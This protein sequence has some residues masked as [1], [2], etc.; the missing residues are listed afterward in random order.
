MANDIMIPKRR[1]RPPKGLKAA[2]AAAPVLSDAETLAL[3]KSR[4]A[5]LARTTV[6]TADASVRGLIVS[7][8]AG[9]GKSYTVTQV[10]DGL[11]LQGKVKRI[12]AVSG[13]MT[14]VHL[15]MLLWR[16]REKGNVVVIDDADSIY[17]DDSALNVLKAALDTKAKREI[18]WY[19]D[20]AVLK[21]ENVDAQFVFEGSVVFITNLNF[22]GF[23]SS[24]RNRLSPHIEALMS[25]SLYLDLKLHERRAVMLWI[26]H[27]IGAT[28]LLVNDYG[29]TKEQQADAVKF[30][31]EHQTRTRHL[32]VRSAV[33]IGGMIRGNPDTWREDAEILL[34]RD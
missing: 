16:N 30:L 34:L 7:G 13:Y 32:S 8:A 11:K 2:Q 6:A 10:L 28:N 4:F 21:A 3:V 12:E 31:R 27:L 9:I 5:V 18:S 14:A 1:G 17:A 33:L 19:A 23:L 20:S 24:G 29:L 15:Y 22:D 26:E 25:R